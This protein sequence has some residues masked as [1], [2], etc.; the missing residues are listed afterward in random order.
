[1]Y[2]VIPIVIIAAVC[3]IRHFFQNP[4]QK[5]MWQRISCRF[6]FL[7]G[8]GANRKQD[9]AYTKDRKINRYWK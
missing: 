3:G 8:T 9:E 1:M 6:S 2:V 7:T 4:E 5:G